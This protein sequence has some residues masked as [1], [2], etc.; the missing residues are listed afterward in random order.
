MKISCN[1]V[2]CLWTPIHQRVSYSLDNIIHPLNKWP[3]MSYWCGVLL[4]TDA[5]L[6]DTYVP[7]NDPS[8]S[9]QAL[10]GRVPN[11]LLLVSLLEHLCSLYETDPEKN[12]K[13]FNGKILRLLFYWSIHVELNL[14]LMTT[15]VTVC[16]CSVW[17]PCF[18]SHFILAKTNSQSVYF[19]FLL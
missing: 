7:N 3:M 13:I 14:C 5:D 6:T 11:Y 19:F 18:H 9:V 10:E 1:K 2:V 8:T 15:P 4:L 16:I 12:K 17:P